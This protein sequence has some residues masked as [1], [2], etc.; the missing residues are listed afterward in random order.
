MP[1]VTPRGFCKDQPHDWQNPASLPAGTGLAVELPGD[2]DPALVAG[3]LGDL[4][5]IRIR[6]ATFGDGRGFGLGRAL[7]EQGYQGRLRA[8]GPLI[9]DQFRHALQSG[10]D[11]VE[12]DEAQAARQPE[13]DWVAG[14][15]PSYRRKLGLA[16]AG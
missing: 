7:R 3:R 14:Q 2:A 16:F 11:E 12:I 10:F 15:W 4:A 6:F 9:S 13:A 5:L 1:I 8:A